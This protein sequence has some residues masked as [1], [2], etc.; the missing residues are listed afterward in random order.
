[1]VVDGGD[2]RARWLRVKEQ[3]RGERSRERED[4][5]Q[6][7]ALAWRESP[8]PCHREAGGGARPRE[9]WLA[10]R[11]KVED[12]LAPGGLECSWARKVLGYR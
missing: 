1:M 9:R 4:E 8:R 6:G 11:R 7:V 3:R 2:G 10:S 12:N 5:D